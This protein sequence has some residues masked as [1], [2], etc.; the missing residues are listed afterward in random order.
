MS[1]STRRR[2]DV[3]GWE[4]AR[5]MER[6]G[7]ERLRPVNVVVVVAVDG[8]SSDPRHRRPGSIP[9]P[10]P[11]VDFPPRNSDASAPARA[12]TARIVADVVVESPADLE[13]PTG[14]SATTAHLAPAAFAALSTPHAATASPGHHS[15]AASPAPPTLSFMDRALRSD[16]TPAVIHTTST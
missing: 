2:P 4:S 15:P 6:R 3:A 8:T 12:A 7:A 16:P 13:F 10:E 9:T 5:T 11:P 14:A 1:P